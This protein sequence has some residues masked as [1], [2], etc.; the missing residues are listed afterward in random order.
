MSITVTLKIIGSPL[1]DNFIF[2][3]TQER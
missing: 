1:H 3:I 2:A